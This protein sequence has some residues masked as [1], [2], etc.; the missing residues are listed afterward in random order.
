[1]ETT[2]KLLPAPAAPEASAPSEA[3][4]APKTF[5]KLP[6]DLSNIPDEFFD[7]FE[8]DDYHPD[9][10]ERLKNA[11][12]SNQESAQAASNLERSNQ[13][14]AQAD[15]ELRIKRLQREAE[16]A[17]LRNIR[18]AGLLTLGGTVLAG[19]AL[20]G[21]KKLY[22]YFQN[23]KEASM[24]KIAGDAPGGWYAS[25]DDLNKANKSNQPSDPITDDL[26]RRVRETNERFK[27]DP[28]AAHQERQKHYRQTLD[29]I[30]NRSREADARYQQTMR[31]IDA[32][33]A[34][35]Q[36]RINADYEQR[37]REINE[38][39][40]PH[41]PELDIP[42]FSPHERL[43]RAAL[44]AALGLGAGYG[45][46]KLYQHLTDNQKPKPK[47]IKQAEADP[48]ALS[49]E[50]LML[51]RLLSMPPEERALHL[52]ANPQGG[53]MMHPSSQP[54]VANVI[55]DFVRKNVLRRSPEY[56]KKRNEIAA[57]G[58][59]LHEQKLLEHTKKRYGINEEVQ[60]STTAKPEPSFF[61]KN[62]W[63]LLGA[64][65]L[66]A[67]VGYHALNKDDISNQPYNPSYKLGYDQALE[68]LAIPNFLSSL[69]KGLQNLGTK[70]KNT[71]FGRTPTVT[72]GSQVSATPQTHGYTKAK[73]LFYQ[74]KDVGFG[75]GQFGPHDMGSRQA[76]MKFQKKLLDV[77]AGMSASGIPLPSGKELAQRSREALEQAKK[78]YTDQGKT[79]QTMPRNMQRAFA[80][81]NQPVRM[82]GIYDSPN[83]AAAAAK[84]PFF[85]DW[86]TVAPKAT[87]PQPQQPWVNQKGNEMPT[88]MGSLAYS[89]TLTSL[90]IDK[91]A[92][93]R[94]L[95]RKISDTWQKAKGRSP[96]FIKERRNILTQA[97]DKGEKDMLEKLKVKK[98]LK[99]GPPAEASA[100]APTTPAAPASKETGEPSLTQPLKD[101]W[102][103]RSPLAKAGIGTALAAPLAYGLYHMGG[104]EYT[105]QNIDPVYPYQANL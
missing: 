26:N 65:A 17:H 45:G 63:P 13:A 33:A 46:Y 18:K 41:S 102:G 95:G 91:E 64:G 79:L 105:P 3:P 78:I 58:K 104:N 48:Q 82:R 93:V 21:G 75:K 80:Q 12:T 2:P 11:L 6:E 14:R 92:F 7:T 98:G 35:R 70:A 19:G 96:E 53:P 31:D 74:N 94:A 55:T 71:Y 30:T 86:G 100:P 22:D 32:R 84:Q 89:Q 69:G 10:V 77:P 88:K 87:L 59:A 20:Y 76:Q 39:Y 60:P 49:E 27:N 8:P 97:K 9:D 16:Q 36:R 66:A 68:K 25:K 81:A 38:R 28:R 62:K 67:G 44:L 1:M 61:E 34:E 85:D 24:P 4:E 72:T 23:K 29:D 47:Q 50:D 42:D 56:I 83:Q 73:D 57:Q 52:Q 103:K 51:I 40:G 101:W 15:H 5:K 54:K 90:G 43:G 99:E 37:M